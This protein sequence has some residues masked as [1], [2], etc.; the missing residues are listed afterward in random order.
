MIKKVLVLLILFSSVLFFS[1]GSTKQESE[2]Q[3]ELEPAAVSEAVEQTEAS[4][5]VEQT[6]EETETSDS[7]E[8]SIAEEINE[9]YP[10]LEEIEEPDLIEISPQ[11]LAEQLALAEK[12]TEQEENKISEPV[13]ETEELP[14]LPDAE[15]TPVLP[16]VPEVPAVPEA[17]EG[18]EGLEDQEETPVE[19]VIELCLKM[20]YQKLLLFHP[21]AFRLI[22]EKLL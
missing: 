2:I 8:S 4:D 14:P 20:P 1:C 18:L 21:A 19:P 10:P 12:E 7:Q 16:A 22:K 17:L 3:Q 15:E 13:E 6:A 9:M 11:E 5:S